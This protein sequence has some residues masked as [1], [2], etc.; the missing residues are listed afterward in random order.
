[1]TA[2]VMPNGEAYIGGHI[3]QYSTCIPNGGASGIS[4]G[5]LAYSLSVI[6]L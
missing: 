4:T 2:K 6:P 5:F 1:M 3:G